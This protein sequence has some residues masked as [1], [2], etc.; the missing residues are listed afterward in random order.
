M[1]VVEDWARVTM[2]NTSLYRKGE[3]F[4]L[5]RLFLEQRRHRHPERARNPYD[6][7][8]RWIAARRFDATEVRAV[9]PGLLGEPLLRPAM[10][11]A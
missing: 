9:N 4:A 8:Q 5:H 6:V 7:P 1:E 11:V 2:P 10:V 3:V